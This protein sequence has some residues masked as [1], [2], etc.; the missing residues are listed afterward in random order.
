MIN[1]MR[2]WILAISSL[3]SVVMIAKVRIHSPE[4]GSFQFSHSPPIPN[5]PPS[6]IA[7]A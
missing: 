2:S 3:A 5:G 1:G 6:F 7:M 4:F